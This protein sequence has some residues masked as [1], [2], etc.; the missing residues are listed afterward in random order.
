MVNGY[1]I[2]N[3]GYQIGNLI[4]SPSHPSV[5]KSI[6]ALRPSV[7][8]KPIGYQIDNLH[9]DRFKYR[10]N[11][12]EARDAWRRPDGCKLPVPG[13]PR[14]VTY[15]IVMFF[16][17]TKTVKGYACRG[18]SAVSLQLWALC[19]RWLWLR[20]LSA[21][22]SPLPTVTLCNSGRRPLHLAAKNKQ[23]EVIAP[24]PACN[25]RIAVAMFLVCV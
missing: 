4:L 11:S 1:Q 3:L 13:S 24:S 16:Y 15:N 22:V 17:F 19:R 5:T 23:T 14:D 10:L 25:C 7:P 6:T 2:D 20:C 21:T 12:I 18:L 9:P 8:I